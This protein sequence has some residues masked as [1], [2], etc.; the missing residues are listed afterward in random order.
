M[1]RAAL[2]LLVLVT[3]VARADGPRLLDDDTFNV[4]AHGTL[5]VDGALLVASPSAL[6][7]GISTGV[8]ARGRARGRPRPARRRAVARDRQR[9]S[10]AHRR[11]RRRRT[12]RILRA[13]RSRMA[14]VKY[15]ALA[16]VACGCG[17][18][19]GF[20]GATPPLVTFNV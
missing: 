15:L 16:L 19:D 6:P 2:A 10:A 18:L 4:P 17:K 13:A 12:R 8:A 5:A 9:G 7:A 11:E 3:G 1:F 14:T 20:G